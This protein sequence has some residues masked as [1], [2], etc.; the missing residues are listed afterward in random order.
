[1]AAYAQPYK[2]AERPRSLSFGI[3][4][5]ETAFFSKASY[6]V[7]LV[8]LRKVKGQSDNLQRWLFKVRISLGRAR[9]TR[10]EPN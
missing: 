5:S 8:S 4:G 1:M 3:L 9:A 7:I 6:F 10:L 2:M